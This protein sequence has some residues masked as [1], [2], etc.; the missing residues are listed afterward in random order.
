MVTKCNFKTAGGWHSGRKATACR[1]CCQAGARRLPGLSH[2]GCYASAGRFK[3]RAA[4]LALVRFQNMPHVHLFWRGVAGIF[5]LLQLALLVRFDGLEV[6]A[7]S[8]AAGDVEDLQR[9]FARRLEPV[10][11]AA[12]DE[13]PFALAE[14]G[15]ERIAGAVELDAPREHVPRR[16]EAGVGMKIG[17]PALDHHLDT[18]VQSAAVPE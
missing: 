3:A 2:G 8:L 9:L 5:A 17:L 11:D 15:D 10:G 6:D 1:G 7:P 18:D 14:I 4:E 16:I 13:E 12:R